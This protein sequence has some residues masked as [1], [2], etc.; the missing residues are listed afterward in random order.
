MIGRPVIV[1]EAFDWRKAESVERILSLHFG[2]KR[3]LLIWGAENVLV[4]GVIPTAR[5]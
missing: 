3:R 4:E 5:I 2:G 1:V